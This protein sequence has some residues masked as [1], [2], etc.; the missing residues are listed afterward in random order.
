[1]SSNNI[2]KRI[3]SSK[4]SGK[5]TAGSLSAIPQVDDPTL[6]RWIKSI[7]G[8]VDDAS[9]NYVR[10]QDLAKAGFIDK[11]GNIKVPDGSNG[12][13]TEGS[14]IVP[15]AVTNFTANGAYSSITLAWDAP[16]SKY[17]GTNEVYRS[18]VNDFG[19]AINIGSSPGNVYTDYIGNAAKAY[20]WV[21]TVSKFGIAGEL[22]TSV[23]A[24]TSIDI[25]YLVDQLTGQI[26]EGTLSQ[27]L[28]G[29][30]DL[31]EINTE[32]IEK[33]KQDAE[34]TKGETTQA[35]NE[36]IT[37]IQTEQRDRIAE[38]LLLQDGITSAQ[39]TADDANESL[40]IYKES[41]DQALA[42]I[43]QRVNVAVDDATTAINKTEALD[44]RVQ[45]AEENTATALNQSQIAVD[46]AN[47]T[48]Q[49]L[50]S[51][52]VAL[53]DK[54]STTYVNQVKA[55]AEDA[56]GKANT[57]LDEITGLKSR[58][59]NNESNINSMSQTKANKDEVVSI[60]QQALQS[61]WQGDAQAKVDAI[62]IG[63]RNYLLN[64]NTSNSSKKISSAF[65]WTR[66]AVGTTIQ[67]AFEIEII[68]PVSAGFRDRIGYELGISNNA[69]GTNYIGVWLN[70]ASSR[71]IGKYRI[72]SSFTVS[73]VLNQNPT[74][75]A[76]YDQSTGGNFS[77]TNVKLEIGTKITDWSPAP[78][79][80]VKA[81][82]D[83]QATVVNT[84]STKTDTTTA[85]ANGIN[86]LSATL[87]TTTNIF[88]NSSFNS[89]NGWSTYWSGNNNAESLS[90]VTNWLPNINGCMVQ[91]TTNG[92]PYNGI[93]QNTRFDDTLYDNKKIQ[94]RFLTSSNKTRSMRV[95]IHYRNNEGLITQSWQDFTHATGYTNVHNLEFPAV[96]GTRWLYV[97][98][99]ENSS[100]SFE[101][102]ILLQPSL[103][104][105]NLKITEYTPSEYDSS[106]NTTA[107][108]SAINQTNATVSNLN[109]QVQSIASTTSTLTS[110][111]NNIKQTGEALTKKV[112]VDLTAS[113][114]AQDK[115]Y[116][117]GIP[118]T[119]TRSTLRVYA[120]LG[121]SANPSWA[122]HGGGYEVDFGWE[123]SP[124]G[125]GARASERNII[126]A[127]WGWVKDGLSPVIKI[128][129]LSSASIEVVWLRG[130][131]KYTVNIPDNSSIVMPDNDDKVTDWND[132]NSFWW[133]WANE[134]TPPKATYQKTD[135]NT[136]TITQ[137][138]Q[139]I[140]GM[141]ALAML[142]IN[143]NGVVSGVGIA[144]EMINGQVKSEIGFMA[145]R[146]FFE[147]PQ[148]KVYPMVI[149]GNQ[150]VINDAVI[151]DGSINNAKIGSLAA[152]KI[153]SGDIS[154]DRMRANIVQA[155]QG[156]FD[157]LSVLS[158]NMGRFESYKAGVGRGVIEGPMIWLYDTAG[159]NRIF[160]G[161]GD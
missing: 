63:G 147:S 15:K 117:V 89:V 137:Q 9:K 50:Y 134:Y 127:S 28:K 22:S 61:I 57:S 74:E 4:A 66:L 24:E 87:G 77:V 3:R 118:L 6:Q 114:F 21:R 48:A 65:D 40:T 155:A 115:C 160:I 33:A 62:K 73:A 159:V 103:A 85:V 112:E 27:A 32:N 84:Y 145:D 102:W 2:V 152:D 64:S 53:D 56:Q 1:M 110:T 46:K 43:R 126:N 30:V 138:A 5:A 122:Q 10:T 69:G 150:T 161:L 25:D 8:I 51:V 34:N 101:G 11:E 59:G 26:S 141:K 17:F 72:Q 18:E 149:N 29:K 92:Q 153:T 116:P 121:N 113:R 68:S 83:F 125:W 31:I 80:S 129:Q 123:V 98:I 38:A 76:F 144:S 120:T 67:M 55:T 91:A 14:T 39:N 52:Q 88:F 95:G 90:V 132:N 13:N 41:N 111:V 139:V 148:G 20:Y 135:T 140:N 58:V 16:Q 19:K 136:V 86:A 54:A 107:N 94:L 70:N 128:D 45:G 7:S 71:P 35:I 99:V 156:R 158:A 81:L 75:F 37:D 97:M 42:T 105:G 146:F 157:S 93:A 79:D 143:N 36:L 12:E 96:A 104:T 124:I 106:I 82:S 23:Y 109:G 151:R 49:M 44:G 119:Y 47:S 108:A 130:G 133:H 131:G 100:D 60:T 142:Q 154:A 78:E